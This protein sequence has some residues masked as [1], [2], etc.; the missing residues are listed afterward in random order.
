LIIDT[1]ETEVVLA[2]AKDEEP[3]EWNIAEVAQNVEE[4]PDTG[5]ATWV[6]VLLTAIVNIG[7]FLRKKFIK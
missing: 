2:A 3:A 5:A 1:Q 7:F 6:L 4:I